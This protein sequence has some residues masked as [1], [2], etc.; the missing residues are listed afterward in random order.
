MV[1]GSNPGTLERKIYFYRVDI[2]QDEEGRPLVFD[3]SPALAFIDSLP[4]TDDE[5]GR[6]EFDS[7]GNA[8]SVRTR[9]AGPKVNLLFGRVRR[10]GLPQLEQ[11]GN[12]T[13]LV[14]ASDE[15][16]LE[17]THIAFF[18][19]NIVGAV[20]NH[21]GPR[22]SRLG[23][24]LHERSQE[25]VP[26]AAFRQLLRSDSAA[27]LERLGDLRVLE[28]TISPSYLDVVRQADRSLADAFEASSRVV[29]SPKE[30]V[31]VLRPESS[32]A[33]G[34]SESNDWR[35]KGIADQ[36]QHPGGC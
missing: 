15:G 9:G 34:V 36:R 8:L 14:L 24:F 13:D 7:D 4:F 1:T 29:E 31:L 17:E 21:F 16:L 28:F 25:A 35:T 32:A 33:G 26:R 27:Q 30:L 20:Y 19:K 5:H 2:G 22:V 12:I 18:Q 6:Y 3:P 10:N 23:S 11:S